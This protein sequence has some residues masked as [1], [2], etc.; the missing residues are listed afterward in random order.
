[1]YE[2]EVAVMIGTITG[3]DPSDP[4]VAAIRG[5]TEGDPFFVEEV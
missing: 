1:L 5:E 2:R 4:F 3:Q